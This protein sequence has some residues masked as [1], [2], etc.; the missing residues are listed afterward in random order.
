MVEEKI[1]S[2]LSQEEHLIILASRVNMDPTEEAMLNDVLCDGLDWSLIKDI[3][4]RFGI[5]SLLF[6]HLSR[7]KYSHCVPN[8]VMKLFKDDYHLQSLKSFI[9]HSEIK[10]IQRLM[11]K[12]NIPVILLKGAA[13]AEWVYGDIALRPMSDIDILCKRED[14]QFV[15]DKFID[16]GFKQQKQHEERYHSTLHIKYLTGSCKHLPTFYKPNLPGV[17]VHYDI[18]PGVY[19]DL[20]EMD[21]V[22]E[23]RAIAFDSDGL[24][25]NCLLLEYQILHL[26]IHLYRH[27]TNENESVVLYWFSDIHEVVMKH[28]EEIDWGLICDIANTLKVV[29]QLTPVL[30]LLKTNWNTPI[31]ENLVS[32]QSANINIFNLK[33]ILGN[34]FTSNAIKHSHQANS[35]INKIKIAVR[36]TGTRNRFNFLFRLIIPNQAFL[37]HKYNIKNPHLVYFYY[38]INVYVLSKRNLVSFYYYIL[39]LLSAK[40]YHD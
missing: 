28:K 39:F 35:V 9:I 32:H 21:K 12:Y 31:P 38:V 1:T 25:T 15:Q 36:I 16:W 26:L 17:E 6:K 8:E 11:N 22:W 33:A 37:N 14:I 3:S 7:E 29:Y 27:I 34:N 5:Q 19:N 18:F 40:K 2:S 10:K 23:T 13:L 30:D 4:S 24:Q 20:A